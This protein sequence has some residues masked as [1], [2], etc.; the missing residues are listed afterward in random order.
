VRAPVAAIVLAAGASTRMGE[1]KAL[2]RWRERTFVEHVVEGARRVGC[3]PI[4]VVH[5]AVALPHV[6]DDAVLVHNAAWRSGQL[7]SLQCGITALGEALVSGVL[8]LTVDRPH[9]EVDTL[10]ALVQAHRREDTAVWQPAFGGRRGHPI[11]FPMDV[12]RAIS[13]LSSGDSPRSVL[14][15][16]DVAVR[17][18]SV[19]V[20]DAA[21][22]DNLDRPEDLGRL[23]Q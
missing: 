17:R 1:P 6:G 23:P 9:V 18:K 22:L 11:V 3:S 7:E 16:P 15:R 4:V 10:A 2:L 8:V 21:V 12:V 14:R 13:E 5:G 20:A 19:E